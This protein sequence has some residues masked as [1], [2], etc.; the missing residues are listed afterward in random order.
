MP[1]PNGDDPSWFKII[2]ALGAVGTFI[3]AIIVVLEFLKR[4]ES[5]KNE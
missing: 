5:K 1:P 4:K 2:I 3:V